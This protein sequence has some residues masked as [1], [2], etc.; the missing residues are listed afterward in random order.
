M[1][2]ESGQA[3]VEWVALVLFLVLALAAL[4]AL[5]PRVDGRSLGG[6]IAQRITCAAVG[7]CVSAPARH[8]PR[9]AAIAPV[10]PVPVPV[11]PTRIPSKRTPPVRAPR[12]PGR[13]PR[14]LKRASRRVFTLNGLI[15]YLGKSTARGDTNGFS[16]D[17]GDA[18]NCLNPL[19]GLTGNVG[20]TDGR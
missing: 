16:D 6:L 14:L 7:R 4:L 12:K 19:R 10:P 8:G 9:E 17:V 1:R 5:A 18:I 13:L 2:S 20:G 15:C 11:A 3:T